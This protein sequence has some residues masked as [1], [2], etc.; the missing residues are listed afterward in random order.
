MAELNNATIEKMPHETY[1]YIYYF[2]LFIRQSDIVQEPI[3]TNTSGLFQSWIWVAFGLSS[4]FFLSSSTILQIFCWV[5][6]LLLYDKG[7]TTISSVLIDNILESLI[8]SIVIPNT[9]HIIMVI[10]LPSK[11]I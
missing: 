5:L 9:G 3:L 10:R 6:C 8:S 1:I 11:V 2:L 4:V 7:L